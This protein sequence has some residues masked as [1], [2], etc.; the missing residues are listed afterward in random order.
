MM[1]WTGL[2]RCK[3]ERIECDVKFCM[4]SMELQQDIQLECSV[5]WACL[6]EGLEQR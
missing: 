6:K 5:T 4:M 3:K 1:A 2:F